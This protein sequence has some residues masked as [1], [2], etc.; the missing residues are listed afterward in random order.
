MEIIY[1]VKENDNLLSISK[2]FKIP[3]YIIARENGLDE[4]KVGMRILIPSVDGIKYIVKPYE[5]M[6]MIA[7][8]F[9]VSVEDLSKH[10]K[11]INYVF[12]GQV[13]YIP[14]NYEEE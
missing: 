2:Q 11:G 3:A 7:D 13:I 6:Q 4:V 5:T 1:K 14:I 10:N 8:N 9:N 12:M